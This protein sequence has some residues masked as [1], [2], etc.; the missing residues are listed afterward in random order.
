MARHPRTR[1]ERRNTYGEHTLRPINCLVFLA[2]PLLGFQLGAAYYGTGLLAPYHLNKAL[3]YFG[4]ATA[5]LPPLLIVLVLL[6]QQALRRERWQV[7]PW[8]LVGML[9]E[10][11]FWV[12]PLLGI[13]LITGKMFPQAATT[14][15]TVGEEVLKSI[16]VAVGAG[17][18]EEFVF[19]LL[20]IG[21]AMLIFVDL[22]DL[23]NDGVA[24]AAVIGAGALFSIYHFVGR[25][26]IR[27]EF[28]WYE[29]I[30]RTVAG[31][32]LGGV[33]YYRG[34]GIVVGAHAFWNV[35]V[36]LAMPKV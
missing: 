14:G 26:I 28:P 31:I 15:M 20:L 8:V 13:S 4:G 34:F 16:L 33:F 27:E 21:L 18:Y 10:S 24:V 2:L 6:A 3:R 25:P 29:F 35:Y 12:V 17:I 30:F 9:A 5:W 32:Y 1:L 19:R 23:P 22:L 36:F 11:L 7:H